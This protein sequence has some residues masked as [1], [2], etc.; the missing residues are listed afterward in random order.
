MRQ[1]TNVRLVNHE[2]GTASVVTTVTPMLH[3]EPPSSSCWTAPWLSESITPGTLP[4]AQPGPQD[5][6][7]ISVMNCRGHPQQHVLF[8]LMV[9]LRMKCSRMLK[10]GWHWAQAAEL[11]LSIITPFQKTWNS[12]RHTGSQ[13]YCYVLAPSFP[14]CVATAFLHIHML[15]LTLTWDTQ[16]TPVKTQ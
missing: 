9:C 8:S 6:H 2:T 3:S 5:L 4:L 11:T 1:C 16:K 15:L 10:Y 14:T 13:Q 12:H 7:N